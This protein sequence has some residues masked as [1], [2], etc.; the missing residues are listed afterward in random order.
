MTKRH[1]SPPDAANKSWLRRIFTP[2]TQET[3]EEQEQKLRGRVESEVKSGK[4]SGLVRR[5]VDR[6]TTR[7]IYTDNRQAARVERAKPNR[8]Q[9]RRAR[10]M[11][12][13]CEAHGR[14]DPGAKRYLAHEKQRKDQT[15]K[16]AI[17]LRGSQMAAQKIEQQQP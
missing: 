15:R 6:M 11:R 5:I 7:Y 1:I 10:R 13:A 8:K 12:L 16:R 4:L 3:D 17:A 2:R 9:I 14:L